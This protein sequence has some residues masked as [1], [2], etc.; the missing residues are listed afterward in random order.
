MANLKDD[1]CAHIRPLETSRTAAVYHAT[2]EPVRKHAF[3]R[4]PKQFRKVATGLIADPH[5]WAISSVV[6]RGGFQT[7][8]K[9]EAY[10][11]IPEETH[12]SEP[13]T[14]SA[15][16][17]RVPRR[18]NFPRTAAS[19]PVS[20][21]RAICALGRSRSKSLGRP[22][23]PLSS[24]QSIWKDVSGMESTLSCLIMLRMST[25]WG[26]LAIAGPV[27]FFPRHRR[28]DCQI[29]TIFPLESYKLPSAKDSRY[30]RTSKS[31]GGG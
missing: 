26:L 19:A 2:G 12:R 15:Q 31:R 28:A 14:E 29:N 9:K 10:E 13:S 22:R 20:A 3:L 1:F 7:K 21:K 6:G 5:S 18:K 27:V 4:C 11:L 25:C 16:L 8:E 17:T 30:V 23:R 24:P